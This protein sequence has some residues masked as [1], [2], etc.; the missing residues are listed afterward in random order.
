MQASDTGSSS[1]GDIVGKEDMQAAVFYGP[2]SI[3]VERAP[4]PFLQGRPALEVKSCAVCGYD[5][6]VF[7]NGHRKVS[8]PVILGHEICGQATENIDVRGGVRIR[9]GSRVALYPIVPCLACQYCH[10]GQYNMCT[11]LQEIGS[12]LDGGF[13][14]YVG[15]PE[16][17]IKIGGLVQVPDGLSDEEASLLEPL[18]CCLNGIYQMG[19]FAAPARPA[20][21]IGDGPVGLLHLQLFKNL[22]GARTAVVGRVQSRMQKARSMGADAVLEYGDDNNGDDVAAAV[23]DFTGKAGAGSVVIAAGSP[24]A[25]DLAVRVAGKNSKIS[26][27]AGMPGAQRFS[28]DANWLHYN[29]VSVMGAFSSVPGRLEEAARLAKEGIVDLSQIV[30]HRYSLAEVEKAI[31][32]AETYSGLR[33]VINK[34]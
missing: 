2:N 33:A 18:A 31:H 12:T 5:V 17:T 21:I 15:V 9:K 27:F 3:S 32:T 11:D 34:F 10:A 25:F 19:P 1:N 4:S 30:T 13:A 20:V 26:L 29:Q 24:A 22:V 28:L 8:P 7:R 23:M 14:Q 6:R 16:Q